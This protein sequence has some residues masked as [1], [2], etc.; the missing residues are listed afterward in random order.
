MSNKLTKIQR[1]KAHLLAGK[2]LTG[3]ELLNNFGCLA[4]RDVMYRLRNQGVP[5]QS[6]MVGETKHAVY[7][8]SLCDIEV[9]L[10]NQQFILDNKKGE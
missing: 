7:W 5:I 6:I 4:Y 2:P 1:V 3:L 8:I 10:S 9:Y